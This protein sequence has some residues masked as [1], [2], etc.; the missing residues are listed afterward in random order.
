MLVLGGQLQCLR[1][2]RD[3]SLGTFHHAFR[4]RV[5]IVDYKGNIVLDT[6][7]A[8][9]MEV[10]DYRTTTTGIELGHLVACESKKSPFR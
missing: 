5:G 1:A 4:S 8:P 6:F 9:T 2:S 10:T 7:V 3:F